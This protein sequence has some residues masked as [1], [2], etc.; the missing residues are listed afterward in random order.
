MRRGFLV[1]WVAA[2][3]VAG[4]GHSVL[5]SM[6]G[7]RAVRT[8]HLTFY[9]STRVLYSTTQAAA[10]HSYA[11]MASS[12]FQGADV[13]NVDVLFLE[14][15]DFGALLGY[16]RQVAVMAK[17][18]G[19]GKIGQ[20]GLIVLQTDPT[21]K[22]VH[23]PLMHLFMQKR[24]PHAPLWLHEGMAGYAGTLVL[25]GGHGHQVACFGRPMGGRGQL[26]KVDELFGATW[27]QFAEGPQSWYHYTASVLIDYILHAENARYRDR[28]D[29]IVERVSNGEP[30][31]AVLSSAMPGMTM[32]MLNRKISDHS[33]DLQYIAGSPVRGRCP[34]GF[35][36]PPENMANPD[37][38]EITPV[39]AADMKELF[40]ALKKLP[41][42]DDGYPSWYPPE[43]ITR[44]EQAK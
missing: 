30:A 8:Q 40:E 10:E 19:N 44:V 42:R 22:A 34:M 35:E 1:L 7:W 43:V 28:L 13:G 25:M 6:E 15:E 38:R 23:G 21:G 4:C 14:G 5:N 18:P 32:D 36:I 39:A 16:K 31:P 29:G 41:A 24:V 3:L 9:T 27:D 17:V 20:R 12:F 37:Q 33:R 2:L 11:A 26:I